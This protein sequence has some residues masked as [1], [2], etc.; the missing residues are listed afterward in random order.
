M[1]QILLLGAGRSVG[2]FIDYLKPFAKKNNWKLVIGDQSI[3][4][5]KARAKEFPEAR[6]ILFDVFD[7][8]QLKSEI[9]AADVVISMIPAHLHI[10]VIKQCVA[11]EKSVFTA[12][13]VSEEIKGLNEEAANKGLLI[14]MEM[15]LDPGIDHMSAMKEI[16][17]IKKGGGELLSF[18]S[19]TGG[20]IAPESD[21][22]PWN[23]KFT[24]NPRNVVLAGQGTV[25]FIRNGRYKYITYHNLFKRLENIEVP[26][27]G[28]F[29]G[30][31]NRDSLSYRSIY[32]LGNIPT[33][34]RGTL[35]RKGFCS[36]WDV[37]V[38]LGMTDDT[39]EIEQL[40]EMTYR[41]FINSYLVY[42][43]E[44]TV[45]EKLKDFFKLTDDTIIDKLSWLGIL[46][47]KII[48]LK[49]TTPARVLQHLLEE[50]WRLMPEDKDMV[51]MQHLF[52]YKVG[53]ESIQKKT[54]MVVKGE[55][56]EHTSMAKTVGLPLGIAVRLYLEGKLNLVGV[57]VPVLPEIYNPVLDELED[58][59]V[60]FF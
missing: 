54:S 14:L 55:N 9:S 16:D 1:R 45:E 50:K 27:H 48:P 19:F 29:E 2:S 20:L 15:G 25:K 33:I 43:K 44:K 23:Y 58:Y 49:K 59:G 38:Q 12:S 57:H 3:E 47:K 35:R 6:A 30:Y 4:L 5:A 17:E 41:D 34:F 51:V 52:E 24:W 8:V 7:S 18:K 39:Y 26:G 36:A 31:A 53:G 56:A 28:V 22:N 13:Y 42:H 40:E 11:S 60:T 37:F 10:H 32:G 21:N 46:E